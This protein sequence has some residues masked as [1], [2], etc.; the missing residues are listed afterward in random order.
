MFLTFFPA[1]LF[2]SVFVRIGHA[3]INYVPHLE[4][5]NMKVEYIEKKPTGIERVTASLANGF[6]L[7]DSTKLKVSMEKINNKIGVSE[8][9]INI[10]LMNNDSIVP[11]WFVPGNEKALFRFE[12]EDEPFS[13][14]VHFRKALFIGSVPILA[15]FISAYLRWSNRKRSN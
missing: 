5:G 11:I 1:L 15:F 4:K 14:W 13:W 3:T 9:S 7:E 10:Y 12:I 6:A 8:D 2:L